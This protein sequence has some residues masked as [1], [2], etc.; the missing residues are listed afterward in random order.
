MTERIRDEKFFETTGIDTTDPDWQIKS[1]SDEGLQGFVID[2][3][4]RMGTINRERV[5]RILDRIQRVTDL[6]SS[7]DISV[8]DKDFYAE[9]EDLSS[10]VN[11][12]KD[13][14]ENVFEKNDG[15]SILIANLQY[16][17]T[18]S[19]GD[20]FLR[21]REGL[22]PVQIASCEVFISEAKSFD[23]SENQKKLS[24]LSKDISTINSAYQE[25]A[26]RGIK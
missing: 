10:V 19:V 17:I 22:D 8:P 23:W 16:G 3:N 20:W 25:M 26:R 24:K 18:I 4:Q 12:V 11:V 5:E 13:K 21:N 6:G 14:S 15:Y 1:L 9:W 2:A 7:G